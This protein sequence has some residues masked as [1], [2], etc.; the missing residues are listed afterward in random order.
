MTRMGNN[1]AMT[2]KIIIEFMVAMSHSTAARH[3]KR[4]PQKDVDSTL[5]FHSFIRHLMAHCRRAEKINER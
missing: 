4:N 5:S 2:A 1:S 3:V